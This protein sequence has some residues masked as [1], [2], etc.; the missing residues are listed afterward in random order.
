MHHFH[1]PTK[2]IDSA[3]LLEISSK[4]RLIGPKA[5]ITK[6]S[7]VD[8]IVNAANSG[9]NSGNGVCG[10]IFKADGSQDLT[11]ACQ[12]VI[13]KESSIPTGHTAVT[14][15]SRLQNQGIQYVFHSVGPKIDKSKGG[16]PS[17][18]DEKL[19]HQT[20]IGMLDAAKKHNINSIAMP[21][22]STGRYGY[23]Q[24]YAVHTAL[25]AIRDWLMHSDAN[26]HQLSSIV[27]VIY[28][29][30]DMRMYKRNLQLY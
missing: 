23:N 27:L 22:I 26:R 14:P 1:K 7:N 25:A 18:D 29:P 13:Q 30:E 21:C 10:A 17:S 8:A 6:L 2:S 28:E 3:H 5:D 24:Q 4:I 11:K 19:L 15:A 9:L 12:L 16:K 20:Y